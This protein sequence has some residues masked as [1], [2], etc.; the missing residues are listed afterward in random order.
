MAT[1]AKKPTEFPFYV[2]MV[3]KTEADGAMKGF[4]TEGAAIQDCLDRNNRAKDMEI[5]ARYEVRKPMGEV[6]WQ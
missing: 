3:G 2:N 6:N 1:K 5:K 4:D